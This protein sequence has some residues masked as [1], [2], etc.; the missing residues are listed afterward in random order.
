MGIGYQ[1]RRVSKDKLFKATGYKPHV[2]QKPVHDSEARFRVIVAGRRWGKSLSAAKE[3]EVMIVTPG[4][5]GWIVS[6]SYDLALKVFREIHQ[7][8]VVKQKLKPT[9]QQ[10]S[11]PLLM[12]WEWGSSVE[13]KSADNPDSL[14][15]EGLDWLVFDEFAKCKQRVWEEALR[16][17]L[18]DRQGWALFIGTPVGYNWA[19]DLYKRGKDENHPDWESFQSPSWENPMLS[20]ADIEEARNTLSDSTFRQ[21]YGAEFT[22]S[23]GQVYSEFQEKTHVVSACKIK[24]MIQADWP[25][26]RAIDFGYNNPTVVLWITI[27]PMDRVIIY[28][29]YYMAQ[30]TI[31]E[32]AHFMVK[33][34]TKRNDLE[35]EIAKLGR[36]SP[37]VKNRHVPSCDTKNTQYEFTVCDVSAKA[38]RMELLEEG[39][40]CFGYSSDVRHGLE[41]VRQQLIMRPGGE[42]DLPGLI[43]S[44]KCV[45]TIK[46]F[47]LY[48]Y[49][50]GDP[51]ADE[52][53]TKTW[54][55]ALDALR[56]F[57]IAWRKGEPQ[58]YMPTR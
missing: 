6:K 50:D 1:P 47:N 19:Y 27:D 36:F 55:H 48:A 54:D 39:I 42:D 32:T 45:N 34:V 3:A 28:D 37:L 12:E 13:G 8:L 58:S 20:A 56:Y 7:D 18:T 14:L 4:T 10:M 46:E 30:R 43:V 17:T 5:R 24:A 29:E 31:Q 11:G 25:R 9:K 21:E 26:Y 23:A 57:I 2:G 16:P 40:P 49:P 15:G 38:Q 22:V 33:R 35:A 52:K 44:S 53:P 51:R 41:L